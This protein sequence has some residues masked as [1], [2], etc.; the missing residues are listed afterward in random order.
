MLVLLIALSSCTKETAPSDS[1]RG[2]ASPAAAEARTVTITPVDLFKGDGKKFQPFLGLMSGAFKV[3]YE[4]AKH[5][6]ALDIE[7]WKD[8]KKASLAGSL[9][10][11]FLNAK[12]TDQR[13]IELIISIDTVTSASSNQEQFTTIK[14]ATMRGDGSSLATFTI[15][16]DKKLSTRGLI[17]PSEPRSLTDAAPIYVWGMQATSNDM[18]HTADFS[19]DSL[20]SL[21]YGLLFTLRFD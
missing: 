6:A 12:D 20:S 15:P 19:P 4:G 13:E 14:V 1:I 11:L 16:W 8:G 2:N 9:S 21:E 18:I 5:N 17:Q 7:L 10:D 3:Q